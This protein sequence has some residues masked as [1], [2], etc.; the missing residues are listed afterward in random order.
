MNLNMKLKLSQREFTCML[1]ELSISKMVRYENALMYIFNELYSNNKCTYFKDR[2]CNE[3][4]T[5][6]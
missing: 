5:K 3:L 4:C 6:N 2:Y 1:N